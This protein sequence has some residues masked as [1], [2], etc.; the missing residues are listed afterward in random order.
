VV[1]VAGV[2]VLA[3]GAHAASAGV[4]E[5]CKDSSNGMA[6]RTFSF[7]ITPTAGSAFSRDVKAGF[8]SGPITVGTTNATVTE[9]STVPA[10]DVAKIDVRP[11]ARKLS[12]NLPGRS[13]TVATGA[14]TSSETLIR[15]FNQPAGGT[16]GTLKVCKL[17]QTPA[18][19]GHDYS[20]SVNG[21][22]IVSAPAN[23]AF[24]DPANW[25]CRILGTFQ[26]GS[27]VTVQEQIPPGQEIQFIDTD[28]GSNLVDFNTDTGTAIVHV[29]SGTTLVLYDNEPTPPSGTGFIEVCKNFGNPDPDVSGPFQFTITDSLGINYPA[30]VNAGFCSPAIQINAGIATVTETQ[31]PGFTLVDVQTNPSDRLLDA[32]LINRT[33]T[34]E[35]P[36]SSSSNDET[37]VF[38]QNAANRGQLKVCKALGAASADLVGQTFNFTASGSNG[39]VANFDITAAA[40]TQC[41]IVGNFPIGSTVNVTENLDHSP[42][43]PGEFIDTTG[44]G[45]VVIA[46][47]VNTV[48]IT[49]TARGL[50]EVCKLRITYLAPT[51]TQPTFQFKI[52]GGAI[53]NVRA[54]TCSTPRRVSVGNHTVTELASNDYDLVNIT[55]TPG[56]LVG[57]SVASRTVTVSVPYGGNE[58]VVTFDNRPK[59]GSVK[60]CKTIPF[61]STDTLSGK[62]Y[63]FNMNVQVAP[64]NPGV[65]APIPVSV[66][67]NPGE[68][69]GCSD[70]VL[71]NYPVIQTDGSNTIIGVM[72]TTVGAF[73][74][75]DITLT[76]TRGYCSGTAPA[77]GPYPGANCIPGGKNTTTQNV[78]FFLGPGPQFPTF[79]QHAT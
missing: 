37:Q 19:L 61:T 17:T 49:N 78:N 1:A 46:N 57:G 43:A 3:V 62:T 64:G 35:V 56:R 20:F 77:P 75:D 76:G 67:I 60:V 66:T 42:M 15:F 41:R 71:S 10:T 39:Q 5:I 72:E 36:T 51:T 44:E 74:V 30:T 33:A 32:N 13:V 65:F 21:G 68:T 28:P 69:E 27:N 24:D 23:D 47:G 31:R 40:T 14:S 9:A 48:T 22:P 18:F 50:L 4:L 52:D 11:S 70:F 25:T 16:A 29:D 26:V 2:G 55:V 38:F 45:P 58:T 73:Q 59:T 34:V 7:T 6:G 8:C 53:F 79:F 12:E 54:G 63:N